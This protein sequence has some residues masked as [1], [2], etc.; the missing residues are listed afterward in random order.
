MKYKIFVSG[1]QKELKSER[2]AVKK[3][4][5][6]DALLKE[7]FNVFLFE[8]APA[9]CKP[10]KAVYLK[11]VRDCDVYIVIFGDEYG[12]AAQDKLS[13]TEEEFREAHKRAK[14]VLVYIIAVQISKS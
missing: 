9:G 13:A 8:N 2:L 10:S 6:S 11:E 7:Y 12:K 1:A 4:V 14:Y 3:L 5:E